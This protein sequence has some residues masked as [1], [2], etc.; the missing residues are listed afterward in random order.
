MCS[1]RGQ[2]S[3]RAEFAGFRIGLPDGEDL[4]GKIMRTADDVAGVFRAEWHAEPEEQIDFD[5][6][7]EATVMREQAEALVRLY[8]WRATASRPPCEPARARSH[9]S[10]NA[11]SSH[12]CAIELSARN[13]E[14]ISKVIAC[15]CVT[16]PPSASTIV[17]VGEQRS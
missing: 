7:T 3:S 13:R 14:R 2:R 16:M 12:L 10:R 17:R 1:V 11:M 4:G 8:W 5:D 15:F 9:R 6:A